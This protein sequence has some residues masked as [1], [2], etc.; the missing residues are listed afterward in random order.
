MQFTSK[1]TIGGSA[2]PSIILNNADAEKTLT[3]W[4][5]CSLGI[6]LHWWHANKQQSGRGR[7]GV[8]PLKNLPVLNVMALSQDQLSK[9]VAI[10]DSLKYKEL[11]PI[12]EINKDPVREEIDT[13]LAIEILGVDPKMIVPGGPFD[14]LRHKLALEPSIAGSKVST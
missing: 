3:L 2:W 13:K 1:K 9:A 6:L 5:N 10:F 11:R 7:I 12:N 14:L 8:S 4:G